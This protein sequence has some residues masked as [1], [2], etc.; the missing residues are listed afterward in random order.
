[1]LRFTAA[2][3]ERVFSRDLVGALEG[4]GERPWLELRKGKKLTEGWLA[5]Q[6]RPYGVRPRMIRIGE[7]VARGYVEEEM[8]ET[9]RRY[10]PK[11]EVEAVKAELAEKVVKGEQAKPSQGGGEQNGAGASPTMKTK[12]STKVTTKGS[13]RAVVVFA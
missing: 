9:F 12:Q 1:L 2:K 3:T 11:S 5:Q 10:I 6:L 7:Q 8:M 13:W 4:C